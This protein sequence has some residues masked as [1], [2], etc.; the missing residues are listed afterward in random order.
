[1][2]RHPEI[3]P[4]VAAMRGSVYSAFRKPS[5][6]DEERIPLPIGDTWMEPPA[7]CR[8]EDLKVA[9][10]PGMHRYA[11]VQGL[12]TLVNAVAERIAHRSGVPTSPRQI[13]IAAGATGAL[14]AAVGALVA[15]GEE[16]LLAAPYWPLISGIV[17]SFHG[18]PIDV[19]LVGEADDAEDAVARFE[20]LRTDRTVAVY[21]NTPHNPTGRCLPA[22]WLA[23][24]TSWARDN[25]LWILA[26]EVYEDYVYSGTHTYTRPL[27]PERTIA[28]HSFSKAF[29]MAGNRCGYLA[30]PEEIVGAMRKVSTHTF[31]STPTASQLAA[32]CAL[33]PAGDDWIDV[34][35]ERYRELGAMAASRLGVDAPEGSTFL[36]L[37]VAEA[38]DGGDLGDF[39]E[40]CAERG[41]LV[42]PGPSFGPYPT[43]IRVC[44][45]AAPPERVAAG[46]EILAELIGR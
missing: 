17:R 34:A 2:P 23:A 37:D 12:P 16:V 9:D 31:Y 5:P 35:R 6:S 13:L 11:P 33:S 15:P 14:G 19:P 38:L 20:A 10:H 32:L 24:L 41:L 27:A 45:T 29:G 1:M 28:V 42:A 36:F 44:F 40:R 21:W 26:D 25:D 7:G 46:I 30:G 39:L 8:M 43:H 3:A 4:S 18:Q 22:D